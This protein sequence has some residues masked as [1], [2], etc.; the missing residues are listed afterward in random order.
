MA[1]VGDRY[2][3]LFV[4]GRGGMGRV[5]VALE[6]G[7]GGFERIVALKRLLP[8]G[9]QDP[10]RKEMFLREARLAALLA[11]PNVVHAFAF[12]ELYGELFLAME[13]IEGEP[14]SRV[15]SAAEE[16]GDALAPP[17]V[18]YVL[19][20]VCDGLHAAHELRDVGGNA[21]Q[22]VHRDVSPHNLMVAYEG[23]VKLLDFGV[24]KFDSEGNA[25]RTGEVKGKMAYMSPEQALGDKLDRRSDLFSVGAILYEC[26]TGRRM[27][28]DGTDVDLMRKLALEEPPR[29]V[30][31]PPALADLYHRL[32]ARSP[33]HRPQSAGDVA[34]E[35]RAF[36]TSA[37]R[38]PDTAAVRSLM[39]RL[40][41]KDAERRRALLTD[42]LQQADP[43]RVE[44][45]R[46]SLE[47]GEIYARP[48]VTE[49]IVVSSAAIARR[50]T[51]RWWAAAAAVVG[52]AALGVVLAA[53]SAPARSPARAPEPTVTLAPAPAPM[54]APMPSDTRLAPARPFTFMPPAVPS[55]SPPPSPSPKP[56]L[57]AK[58]PDVDPSPF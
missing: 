36:A 34:T 45:L 1:M 56:R 49:P 6:R 40:F 32:V 47:P 58:P 35:L 43:S 33:E 2:E 28:G 14:L 27:W 50:G 9:A 51:P 16:G 25:T 52:L 23:H 10:R 8:E 12:G 7:E 26:L 24:A 31:A 41:A 3:P 21:L 30:D 44:E 48:T 46:R 22:V 4:V 19:A 18:A 15:L 37:G 11:H 38:A 20:E 53:V 57:R 29:L 5:E 39:T 17:L 55:S 54:P 42:R 13:Y